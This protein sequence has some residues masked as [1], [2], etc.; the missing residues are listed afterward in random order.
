MSFYTIEVLID[1][2]F[3]AQVAPDILRR[4]A[5]ATVIQ[6]QEERSN[7]E[8][9]ELTL[10]I[11]SDDALRDLNRRFVGLDAPTDVLA[12]PDDTR[13][14][15]AALP[16]VPRYLGDV[17][18]SFPR[19]EAQAAAAGHTVEA[20]LQLLIIHGVLHLLG[21][22]DMEPEPRGAMWAAQATILHALGVQVNL[23]D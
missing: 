13:G 9:C 11:T 6:Q 12:F 21:H 4:A 2:P 3:Q 5:L 17:I 23:P 7:R 18:I 16:G 22:D 20:E 14:P 8:Q 10:A 1:E 15:F 19:A